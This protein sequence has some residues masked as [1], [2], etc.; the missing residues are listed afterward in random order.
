MID[1]DGILHCDSC[2]ICIGAD[3]LENYEYCVGSKV[4]C[5]SCHKDLQKTGYLW[6]DSLYIDSF[7]ANQRQRMLC[8]SGEVKMVIRSLS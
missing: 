5:G 2:Q 3:Y 6:L 8:E 1:S 7:R 4:I